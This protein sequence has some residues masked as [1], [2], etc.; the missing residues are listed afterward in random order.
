MGH[1]VYHLGTKPGVRIHS[2]YSP[3]FCFR[4]GVV[5]VLPDRAARS[6]LV[7]FFVP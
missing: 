1:S 7:E 4:H 3:H 6:V 5:L 2:R